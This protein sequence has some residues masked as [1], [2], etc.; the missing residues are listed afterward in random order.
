MLYRLIDYLKAQGVTALLTN[1]TTGG[2]A[3]EKTDVGISSVIDTWILMRDI[4]L[5]GER[6]RALYVLKSRGMAHSNQVR[7]FLLSSQGLDLQDVYVGPE[8]VL[9]G[10]MRAAQENREKAQVVVRQEERQLKERQLERRRAALEAQIAALRVEFQAV[11]DES[12]LVRRQDEAREKVLVDDRLSAAARRG[13]DKEAG[14]GRNL[15]SRG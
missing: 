12:R 9:T 1:L 2:A 6:N 10:S 3:A 13:A 11:E 4:E 7:E 15:R 8:G 5:G 14:N